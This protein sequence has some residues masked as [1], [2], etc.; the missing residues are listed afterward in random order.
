MDKII[1]I[2]GDGNTGKTTVIND[3][4][5][6][7][8]NTG[9]TV[10][11]NKKQIG[12]NQNDFTA[13]LSYKGKNIAFLSMGDYRTV[14]DDYVNNYRKCDVFIT[15]LNKRFANIGTVWLK[16]SDAIYK[17]DKTEATPVDNQK[18]MNRVISMI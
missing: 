14:V 8:I 6:T 17:V 16:N 7:L 13:V 11:H 3:I 12:G 18:V 4:Y 5:D 2:Y 9:A 15:A 10:K 1:T